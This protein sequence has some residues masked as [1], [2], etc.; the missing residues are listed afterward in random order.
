MNYFILELPHLE[1]EINLASDGGY[2]GVQNISNS[3]D[4]I[5]RSVAHMSEHHGN[6]LEQVDALCLIM[7]NEPVTK[8]TFKNLD[9]II[10]PVIQ[11]LIQKYNLHSKCLF[12]TNSGVDQWQSYTA[13]NHL[14]DY[15]I[16]DPFRLYAYF[17]NNYN[18]SY[19]VEPLKSVPDSDK[20][21]CKFGKIDKMHSYITYCLLN[22]SNMLNPSKGI[23]SLHT[24]DLDDPQYQENMTKA[25]QRT[26]QSFSG[27]PQYD[28]EHIDRN[29]SSVGDLHPED[30]N[31]SYGTFHY[32]GF[33]FDISTFESTGFSI[34]RET[35]AGMNTSNFLSEKYWIPV[36]VKHP[37]IVLG[38]M[39]KIEE[40]K[41]DG[42]Q[43]F[44]DFELSKICSEI[45]NYGH[46]LKHFKSIIQ[47]F[48]LTSKAQLQ[49][50]VDHNYELYL[51]HVNQ[52]IDNLP[53]GS[54][55][56]GYAWHNGRCTFLECIL[57]HHYGNHYTSNHYFNF[58]AI[59]QA[60]S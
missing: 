17:Q 22:D 23:W 29:N 15:L 1:H 4:Y 5:Q 12:L 6:K 11:K 27:A 47:K 8:P 41:S 57:M 56:L 58:K 39:Q 2:H 59:R 40:L 30:V 24:P 36:S 32:T 3:Y 31:H 44:D 14:I 38:V 54:N 53:K 37:V 25:I 35:L 50:I 7:L 28:L 34:V 60:F 18:T 19:H 49:E 20:F 48:Y 46:M 10:F 51:K 26:S 9:E 42:Y 45:T 43:S 55:H 52:D 13:H 33:P 21:M 16:I